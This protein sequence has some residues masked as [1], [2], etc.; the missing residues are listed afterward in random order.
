[1]RIHLREAME[2]ERCTPT[3]A[4]SEII[5]C[6]IS[7]P[8]QLA[9]PLHCP[10]Y[11]SIRSLLNEQFSALTELTAS[12]SSGIGATQTTTLAELA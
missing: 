2:H 7:P 6:L 11:L 3:H 12:R 1:M 8:Q 9:H 10:S 4:D 5:L